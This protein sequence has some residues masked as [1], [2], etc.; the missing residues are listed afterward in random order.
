[1]AK[2]AYP[3]VFEVEESGLVSVDFPDFESCYTGGDDIPDAIYMAADVLALTLCEIENVGKRAPVP[4]DIKSITPPVSGFVS[5]VCCDTIEYRRRT[6]SKAVK[7]T[8]SIPSWLNEA[9][10]RQSIN[11]SATLQ[12]ALMQQLGIDN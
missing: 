11:F 2:Y 1:M 4:S 9:A 5:M 8:L 10:E 3:A 12:Q 6:D 7:K